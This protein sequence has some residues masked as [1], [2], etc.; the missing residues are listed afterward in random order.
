MAI[1]IEHRPTTLVDRMI[2]AVAIVIVLVAS[3]LARNR[4]RMYTDADP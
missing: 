1:A 2:I 4:N 3:D